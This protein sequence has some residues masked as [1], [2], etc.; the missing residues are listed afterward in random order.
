M[1]F[2]VLIENARLID[3]TG[4]PACTGSLAVSGGK[5]AAVGEIPALTEAKRRIDAAGRC[6]TPGFIDVH[7]HA[8]IALFRPDFGAAELAQGLTTLVNGNCGL[9]AAP[10]DEQHEAE[11]CAY[12]RPVVGE[13][14]EALR[15]ST[16]D[17][18]LHAVEIS[19]PLL[20]NAE[21]IG[22]GALRIAAAGFESGDLDAAQERLL[23]KQLERALSDGAVG[24]SLGLGYA[25][26]I[27]Y[28][29]DG[30]IR[31]LAPLRESGV[32]IAVHMRQEGDGVVAALQEMLTVARA[33]KTPVEISHLKAI[34]R[35]NWQKAVPEML[36]LIEEA[37]GE[38]LDLRCDV[39]PYTAGS[40]QLI[41]VLP[42]EVQEGGTAQLSAR[43]RGESERAR[44]RERIETGTDFENILNLVGFENVC[45]TALR[46]PENRAFEGR[47]IAEIAAKLKKDPYDALFDLLAAEDCGAGMIDF[48]ADEADIR[49]I[50]R[51]P[52]AGVISDGTYP[53]VGQPHPRVYGTFTQ[54][55]EH[56][57]YRQKV[58]T[59]EDAVHR[60]TGMAAERFG[61]KGKGLL[62]AGCDGDLCL[63]DP[64][65]LHERAS[66]SDPKR[67]SEGMDLVFV[68]GEIAFEGGK[69]THA[70]CGRA[71]RRG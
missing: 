23:H 9:S 40:T 17:Q 56:Y 20:H 33:L 61:L 66:Y 31:A 1:A 38:G 54:L 55:I 28:T 19:H 39:Y 15:F 34:G 35:R 30:L 71:L 7:R 29:T 58:L 70:R 2:D 57:V 24:V 45:A 48:I 3:G 65:A 22:M 49:A 51:A 26:E 4:A 60:V 10:I 46:R 68:D 69:P 67:L 37:R 52:F 62:K 44:I 14:P 32:P 27:F 16:L 47:S 50:L 21:L 5:I 12:L 18:Y 8:D 11:Q 36:R 42:P 59:L 6:L 53:T 41:H 64:K 43:L 63:F 25:P 13:V